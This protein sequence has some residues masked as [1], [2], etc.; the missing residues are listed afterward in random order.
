MF[1]PFQ[2]VLKKREQ[3]HIT[4]EGNNRLLFSDSQ[5]LE[6]KRDVAAYGMEPV[7]C[8]WS[9]FR[10]PVHMRCPGRHHQQLIFHHLVRSP[11]YLAP[12]LAFGAINEDDLGAT[13]LANTR[14]T[15]GFWI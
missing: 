13:F 3:L 12:T 1:Q 2:N 15:F 14:V 8:P 5:P 4:A 10:R 11:V 9:F 6:V 7:N